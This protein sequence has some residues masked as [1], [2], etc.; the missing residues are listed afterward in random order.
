ML[1][2]RRLQIETRMRLLGKWAAKRY[3]DKV[4][5]GGAEDLPPIQV[6]DPTETARR[7]AFLLQKASQ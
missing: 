6:A 1:Q 7:I 2:H 4:A 3:G 5:V